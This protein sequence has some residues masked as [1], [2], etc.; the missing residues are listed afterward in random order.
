MKSFFNGRESGNS[1]VK[2][3]HVKQRIIVGQ[4]WWTI[5]TKLLFE[6]EEENDK[7]FEREGES[8]CE[9]ESGKIAKKKTF[10][11]I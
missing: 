6:E 9:R 2:L 5:V 1:V 11:K 3:I 8:V 7:W 10:Y 4:K